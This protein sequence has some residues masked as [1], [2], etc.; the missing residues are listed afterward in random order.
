MIFVNSCLYLYLIYQSSEKES[1]LH[2][3]E[4]GGGVEV[5]EADE[6][7]VV[8]ETVEAGWHQVQPQHPPVGGDALQQRD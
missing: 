2:E 6:G 5:R 7:E 1:D 8:V 4:V 3:H